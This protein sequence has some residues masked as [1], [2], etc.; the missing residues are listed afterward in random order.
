[1]DFFSGI[2]QRRKKNCYTITLQVSSAMGWLERICFYLFF[3]QGFL[4][5]ESVVT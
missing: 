2:F 5:T 3:S 4:V 1:M